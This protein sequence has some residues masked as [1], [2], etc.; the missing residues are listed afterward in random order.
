MAQILAYK[1]DILGAAVNLRHNGPADVLGRFSG[2]YTCA[3]AKLSDSVVNRTDMDPFSLIPE[4]QVVLVRKAILFV[5]RNDLMDDGETHISQGEGTVPPR[6]LLLGVVHYDRAVFLPLFHPLD[7]D[8]LFLKVNVR[9]RS[10]ILPVP[11]EAE[12]RLWRV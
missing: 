10:F 3:A 5:D 4:E 1:L 9:R 11:R 6:A 7:V 2:L 8:G 12:Y